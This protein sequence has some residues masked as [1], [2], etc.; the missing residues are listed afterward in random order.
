[1]AGV[2][3]PVITHA[4]GTTGNVTSSAVA[5]NEDAEA[6]CAEINVSAVGGTPTVTFTLE[7]SMD[8]TN[9]YAIGFLSNNNDT[10]QTSLVSTGVGRALLYANLVNT[11][12]AKYIRVVSSAN[13]NVTFDTKVWTYDRD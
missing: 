1:M 13:T 3:G 11:R 8:G 12:F 9:W 7:V 4:A 10:V 2:R 6:Y 5:I